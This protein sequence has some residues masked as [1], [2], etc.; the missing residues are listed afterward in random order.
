MSIHTTCHTKRQAI[1]LKHPDAQ[2]ICIEDIAEALSLIPRFLGHFGAYSVAQHSV[3]C[4][5]IPIKPLQ[6][7]HCLLHDAHEAYTG[8]F[9]RPFLRSLSVGARQEILDIQFN[10]QRTIY[11]SLRLFVPTA[12]NY[13]K[14]CPV[15]EAAD[16][17]V[18]KREI[19]AFFDKPEGNKPHE[20]FKKK[21]A[22]WSAD[23]ARKAFIKR[24]EFLYKL[25]AISPYKYE[26]F[27]SG[28]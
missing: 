24:F 27:T 2:N 28:C 26:E 17:L 25:A 7:L 11:A 22:I 12:I 10:L 23:K 14:Q 1:N 4:S 16:N 9:T 19:T 15:V 5:L 13:N 8:D 3:F 18:L 20:W 6:Q 21:D